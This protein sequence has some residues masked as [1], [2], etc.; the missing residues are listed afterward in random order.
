L[1]RSERCWRGLAARAG[2]LRARNSVT[3]SQ[4]LAAR[5]TGRPGIRASRKNVKV[6]QFH[7][8]TAELVQLAEFAELAKTGAVDPVKF[9][10]PEI[11]ISRMAYTPGG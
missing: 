2:A 7:R 8:F 1:L 6:S 3:A 5:G 4:V 11:A 10:L 9:L